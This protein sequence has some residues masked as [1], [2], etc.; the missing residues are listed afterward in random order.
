M[1]AGK[2]WRVKICEG[3]EVGSHHY[4]TALSFKL[5]WMRQNP[6]RL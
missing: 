2:G 4:T 1:R 6:G 5:A 3:I